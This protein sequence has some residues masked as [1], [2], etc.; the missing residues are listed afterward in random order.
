MCICACVDVVTLGKGVRRAES[1][2]KTNLPSK[3]VPVIV[4]SIAGRHLIIQSWR[5][6]CGHIW[7]ESVS[8]L[9][10]WYG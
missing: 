8:R 3:I 4:S 2:S 6:R 7:T 10:C 9:I 5:R 1:E